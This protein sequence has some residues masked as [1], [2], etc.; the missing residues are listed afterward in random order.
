M[1]AAH[2]ALITIRL[3]VAIPRRG[4]RAGVGVVDGE[5]AAVGHGVA[6]LG[7]GLQKVVEPVI[8]RGAVIAPWRLVVGLVLASLDVTRPASVRLFLVPQVTQVPLCAET[9]GG[10]GLRRGAATYK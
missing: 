3:D 8:G 1:T 9:H 4:F 6:R 10:S 7:L 2:H 5:T